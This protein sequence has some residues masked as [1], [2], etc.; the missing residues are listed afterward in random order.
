MK[1]RTGAFTLIELLVV[2]SII[3]LMISILL[4]ALQGARDVAVQ[5]ACA[6]KLHQAAIAVT[7]YAVDH[8]GFLPSLKSDPNATYTGSIDKLFENGQRGLGRLVPHYVVD[9][10]A[11]YCPRDEVVLNQYQASQP[12]SNAVNS[13]SSYAYFGGMD[14]ARDPFFMPLAGTSLVRIEDPSPTQMPLSI[15]RWAT[16]HQYTSNVLWLDGHTSSVAVPRVDYNQWFNVGPYWFYYV[17]HFA[18]Q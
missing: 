17:R 15:D 10:T 9:P 18:F 14:A 1:Q 8:D 4:P 5:T 2:I 3:A 6:S 13:N 11:F 12:M 16:F 7:N